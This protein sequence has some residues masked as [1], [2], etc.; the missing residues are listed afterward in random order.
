MTNIIKIKNSITP[1]AEP[2]TLEQGEFAVNIADLNIWVG[3]DAK[4]PVLLY[5][6]GARIQVHGW[7]RGTISTP[8]PPLQPVLTKTDGTRCTVVRNSAGR[9]TVTYNLGVLK[10]TDVMLIRQLDGFLIREDFA[11]GGV[12]TRILVC[13]NTSAIGQ[14]PADPPILQFIT[15]AK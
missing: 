9:Y 10:T 5:D 12:N 8:V 1:G 2:N 14:P 7:Y 3:D 11:A 6:A 15:L 4:D 13:R